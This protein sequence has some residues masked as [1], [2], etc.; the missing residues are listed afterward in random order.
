MLTQ[1]WQLLEQISYQ[2]TKVF[3]SLISFAGKD[4]IEMAYLKTSTLTKDKDINNA[5][6]LYTLGGGS[7]LYWI[8]TTG[9]EIDLYMSL[10]EYE[11]EEKFDEK[12]P[13]HQT[14]YTVS[15]KDGRP[16]ENNPKNENTLRS[17]TNGNNQPRP[18]NG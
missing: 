17:K 13:P 9:V 1:V 18:S 7:R 12:Y 5:K 8:A 15:G 4:I 2:Y 16:T 6:E 10:M 14:A 11:K 3:N